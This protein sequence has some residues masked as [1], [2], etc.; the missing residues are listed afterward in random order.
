MMHVE[1]QQ[2]ESQVV[3]LPPR[4]M[5]NKE[6]YGKLTVDVPAKPPLPG[7][8]AR[9]R[10]RLDLVV[11]FEA[12]PV[13][14]GPSHPSPKCAVRT[15]TPSKDEKRPLNLLTPS[16]CV[17]DSVRSCPYDA[18]SSPATSTKHS[19]A[20]LSLAIATPQSGR[21][22]YNFSPTP[23]TPDP[24]RE[25]MKLLRG[26]VHCI[27]FDFDGTLTATPGEKA[28]RQCQKTAELCERA[29]MLAPALQALQDRNILLGI[30]SKSTEFTIRTSLEASG[31]LEFF[32][33][34]IVGKAV[35]LEGKAGMIEDMVASGR[36]GNLGADSLEASLR[37]ILFIDDDIREL[38]RAR[39]R[40]IQTYPAPVEGGMQDQDFVDIFCGLGFCTSNPWEQASLIAGQSQVNACVNFAGA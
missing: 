21:S 38:D 32:T 26:D 36:L 16:S 25:D 20:R 4:A 3:E 34:P 2:E 1:T 31:L 12:S 22:I 30:I 19:R 18:L 6:R 29:P 35:S 23:R 17:S 15:G 5:S 24:F 14:C 40:G 39:G 11:D 13:L 8:M 37:R 10:R 28:L 7:I 33:G 27:F 9:G